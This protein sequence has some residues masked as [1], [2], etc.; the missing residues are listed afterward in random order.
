MC[1]NQVDTAPRQALLNGNTQQR[2]EVDLISIGMARK[3]G[4]GLMTTIL[5]IPLQQYSSDMQI[6]ILRT[7]RGCLNISSP[8]LASYIDVT[9]STRKAQLAVETEY[10]GRGSLRK[11]INSC[12][13]L[14]LLLS[15][16]EIWNIIANIAAGLAYL[17]NPLPLPG[18]KAG[19]ILH[20][21]LSPDS[22]MLYSEIEYK[23]TAYG[24]RQFLLQPIPPTKY[25]QVLGAETERA[26]WYMAP[27]LRCALSRY[28]GLCQLSTKCDIW[29]LGLLLL[30][31]LSL[32]FYKRGAFDLP[33]ELPKNDSVASVIL[34]L[35]SDEQPMKIKMDDLSEEHDDSTDDEDA[36]K[37]STTSL[38]AS[39][40]YHELGHRPQSLLKKIFDEGTDMPYSEELLILIKQC[41]AENPS[42]RPSATTICKHPRVQEAFLRLE[43]KRVETHNSLIQALRL[44]DAAAVRTSIRGF[45]I[46]P[47]E[48][49]GTILNP[50]Y[51]SCLTLLSERILLKN[52][53]VTLPSRPGTPIYAYTDLMRAAECGD[54]PA[55]IES[56]S[57]DFG[58]IYM[59]FAS[60]TALMMAAKEGN[61]EC[62]K[63]LL[64]E[65]G[66]VTSTGE[67]ALMYAAQN[68]CL[69][70]VQL[71]LCEARKQTHY[72]ETALMYAV[73]NGFVHIVSLL[74][75]REAR[76]QCNDGLTALML[77]AKLGRGKCV[78]ILMHYEARMRSSSGETALELAL[79][80]GHGH[81]ADLL[82]DYEADLTCSNGIS[83]LRFAVSNG[84]IKVVPRL[85]YLCRSMESP[86][87]I[88][89]ISALVSGESADRYA[90]ILITNNQ[91]IEKS[92]IPNADELEMRRIHQ[93]NYIS[94]FCWALNMMRPDCAWKVPILADLTIPHVATSEQ[95][96]FSV[97]MPYMDKMGVSCQLIEALLNYSIMKKDH[98]LVWFLTQ[99]IAD[100]TDSVIV[101]SW[102]RHGDRVNSKTK[103]MESAEIGDISGVLANMDQLGYV[104]KNN[105]ALLLA[106]KNHHFECIKLLLCEQGITGPDCV[107]ALMVTACQG[108]VEPLKLLL[109]EASRCD[110][111]GT[112]ALMLAAEM[113]HDECVQLLARRSQIY[114]DRT[115]RT[116]LIR[117]AEACSLGAVSLLRKEVGIGAMTELMVSAVLGEVDNLKKH[118]GE[119]GLQTCCGWTALMFSA[120][121]GHAKCVEL[122]LQ[123]ANICNEDG[124]T[125]MFM[126]A[127]QGRRDC[128]E[129]LFDK[130]GNHRGPNGWTVLMA[131]AY[132]GHTECVEVI[133]YLDALKG[134]KESTSF[135][136]CIGVKA[137]DGRTALM[138]AASQG[139]TQCVK[140]LLEKEARQIDILG[141]CALFKAVRWGHPDCVALLA[142]YE[143]QAKDKN[144]QTALDLA[145]TILNRDAENSALQSCIDILSKE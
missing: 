7:V 58:Y 135:Q 139:H 73:Q 78:A 26:R 118:M 1:D 75:A 114:Q 35:G 81:C 3:K 34:A 83:P 13:K 107:T 39:I 32:V 52:L 61:T 67:T 62:I 79:K 102:K 4:L 45:D 77:A 57:R 141:E 65:A 20:L 128:L 88:N 56:I 24:I 125:A 70:A 116:A 6:R 10:F 106:A 142:S 109:T 111:D 48:I 87:F 49:L 82:L 121:A 134:S 30:D 130:E 21:G 18:K 68:G 89:M 80:Y 42:E 55:V 93:N 120:K 63:L 11:K 108:N 69:A 29:S 129:L 112:S 115:G 14:G 66:I 98:E 104:Y 97:L 92:L 15:E 91:L 72:G 85:L 22:V 136:S 132:G 37:I 25:S 8:F 28:G 71:L 27:E 105:T 43:A 124:R 53:L 110:E 113:G 23:L 143:R 138:L 19:T 145:A 76:L 100:H 31:L 17:H 84:V 127:E 51:A 2:E 40:D 122:L 9:H 46:N 44:N 54:I 144:D 94:A 96:W 33:A 137:Y 133:L 101:S 38:P 5:R 59:G 60:G 47:S 16:T 117:A 50:F 90:S 64:A 126:A 131:A 12:F 36:K 41:I 103:L 140:L 86:Y 119:A 99:Y 95:L 74:A 123:E